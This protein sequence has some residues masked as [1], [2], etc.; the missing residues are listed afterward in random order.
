MPNGNFT[1]SRPRAYIPGLL[2]LKKTQN[3]N[4]KN[5]ISHYDEVLK[6]LRNPLDFSEILGITNQINRTEVK[7]NTPR[8][9]S[10]SNRTG[11]PQP[12]V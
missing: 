1:Q 4:Y 10:V 2:D 9:Q 7:I 12:N 11:V 8:K 6:G 3:Q 5:F